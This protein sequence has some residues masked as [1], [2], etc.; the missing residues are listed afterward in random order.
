MTLTT[1]FGPLSLGLAVTVLVAVVVVWRIGQDR[2]DDA[3]SALRPPR[4]RR[5]HRRSPDER[6]PAAWS[7]GRRTVARR[8]GWG[9]RGRLGWRRMQEGAGAARARAPTTEEVAASMLLLAVALQSGCGVM[10]ALDH[11]ARVA[12]QA[13]AAELAVVAAGLRWGVAEEQAWAE[14]DPRWSRTALALRL[15]REAGVAPSSL[16]LT[17]A[18]DLRSNRLAAVDV[19]AARL[20]VRLVIPLGVAFLPAFVLTTIVPVVLAL[21]RQVLVS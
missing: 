13:A 7:D 20:G 17:G 11:T 6:S 9:S 16:L 15:A 2:V 4:R 19:A 3:T 12:P 21:A 5:A 18:D 10:E 8:T 1:V 14:V